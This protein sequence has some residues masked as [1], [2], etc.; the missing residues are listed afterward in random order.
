M[1]LRRA[2]CTLFVAGGLL[3]AGPQPLVNVRTRDGR[4]AGRN[5]QTVGL[6][7]RGGIGQT[8]TEKDRH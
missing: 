8:Q 7:R 4:G 2:I 6:R 3:W 1:I 5:H